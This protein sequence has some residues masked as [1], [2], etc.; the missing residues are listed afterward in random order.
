MH[1]KLLVRCVCLT[2]MHHHHSFGFF[3]TLSLPHQHIPSTRYPSYF[4]LHALLAAHAYL[5]R[6][7]LTI[8]YNRNSF[9]FWLSPTSH[10]PTAQQHT[11]PTYIE[12][13]TPAASTYCLACMRS[14]HTAR[15]LIRPFS[16]SALPVQASISLAPCLPSLSC[17]CIG[18]CK[19]DL[20]RPGIH[21][22]AISVSP[23]T[24]SLLRFLVRSFSLSQCSRGCTGFDLPLAPSAFHPS[25]ACA[26]TFASA[27]F[28]DLAMLAI[29]IQSRLRSCSFITVVHEL[30]AR[31]S[32]VACIAMRFYTRIIIST[33]CYD[34][35]HTQLLIL[36]TLLREKDV[37]TNLV[38][39]Y[40]LC[41]I[42]TMHW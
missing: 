7:V 11:P 5:I 13:D 36:H 18:V 2:I 20:R 27:I 21:S 15:F 16:L 39:H 10:T 26:W 31:F 12:I 3:R 6:R 19:R 4:S 9:V 29:L 38:A 34:N 8:I 24:F 22:C 17:I 33:G 37:T 14:L 35:H 23:H 28:L 32:V 40:K 1:L 42:T 25:L 30:C 41:Y